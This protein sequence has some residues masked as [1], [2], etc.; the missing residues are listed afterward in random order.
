MQQNILQLLLFLLWLIIDLYFC[1]TV[2]ILLKEMY[3]IMEIACTLLMS[4]NAPLKFW[5]N[6]VLTAFFL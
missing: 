3:S 6:I 4:T 5:S 1:V 2:L